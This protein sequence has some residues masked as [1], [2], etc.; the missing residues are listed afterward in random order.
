MVTMGV[1]HITSR[2][3]PTQ[4]AARLKRDVCAGHGTELVGWKS[5]YQV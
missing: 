3:Q 4:K 5:L 2:F 1:S